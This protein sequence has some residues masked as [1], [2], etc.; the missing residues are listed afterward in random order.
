MA[1]ITRSNSAGLPAWSTTTDMPRL[2]ASACVASTA[3]TSPVLAGLR[4]T[5]TLESEGT[6]SR[7]SSKRFP[8]SSG[9]SPATPVRLPPGLARFVTQPSATGSPSDTN[10]MGIVGVASR[11]VGKAG[12]VET[13]NRVKFEVDEFLSQSCQLASVI[14]GEAIFN[15][16]G[17]TRHPAVIKETLMESVV[18]GSLQCRFTA[19]D[20][21][22]TR[23]PA[24]STV[25]HVLPAAMPPCQQSIQ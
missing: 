8:A 24:S 25:A 13:K 7:S 22:R 5:A 2:R 12:R 19:R 20:R 17:L 10:M 1:P 18:P 15:G 23:S 9:D 11:I 4:R 3:T 6:N 16:Y 14:I 21:T